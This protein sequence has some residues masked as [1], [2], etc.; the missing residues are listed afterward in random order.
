M[1]GIEIRTGDGPYEVI[2]TSSG[3]VLFAQSRKD[4]IRDYCSSGSSFGLEICRNSGKMGIWH[5]TDG[6]GSGGLFTIEDDRY[7]Y[8]SIALNYEDDR[9][10]EERDLTFREGVAHGDFDDWPEFV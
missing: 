6:H 8:P 10:L 5:P 3:D 2:S 7:T 9:E 4:R 1:I